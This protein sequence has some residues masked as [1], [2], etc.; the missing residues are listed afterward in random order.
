[1]EQENLEGDGREAG[2]VRGID[3]VN[4]FSDAVFAVAIT[5][6]K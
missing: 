3:R 2:K 5:L 4:G 6:L 1:M